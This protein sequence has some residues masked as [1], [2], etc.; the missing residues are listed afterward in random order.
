MVLYGNICRMI[1]LFE[2]DGT[3]EIRQLNLFSLIAGSGFAGSACIQENLVLPS[4]EA[5]YNI[6]DI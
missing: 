2:L 4:A 3:L 5:R 1:N 6:S